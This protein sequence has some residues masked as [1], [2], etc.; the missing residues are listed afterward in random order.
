MKSFQITFRSQ[1]CSHL[2]RNWTSDIAM[3]AN[4]IR[5]LAFSL[6]STSRIRSVSHNR[7][8]RT[9]LYRISLMRIRNSNCSYRRLC[10]SNRNRKS[11]SPKTWN[12][13]TS[14]TVLRC[15]VIRDSWISSWSPSKMWRLLMRAA[16]MKCPTC[17]SSS[18][19]S[20]WCRMQ[21]LMTVPMCS[22]SNSPVTTSIPSTQI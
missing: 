1:T 12:T 2:S 7:S 15:W 13:L 18:I 8:R 17:S 14:C 9:S 19:R 6:I 11:L 4:R 20:T 5:M 21:T 3:K 22:S 16:R 10:P